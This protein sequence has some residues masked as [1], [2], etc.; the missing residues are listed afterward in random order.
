[1]S[2][3][4]QIIEIPSAIRQKIEYKVVKTPSKD[5]DG[6]NGQYP[7]LCTINKETG[8]L[9][10]VTGLEFYLHDMFSSGHR[11]ANI[12]SNVKVVSRMMNYILHEETINGIHEINPEI[13]KRIEEHFKYKQSGE[14]VSRD[15]WYK[16]LNQIY[17][18][19]E[20][21]YEKNNDKVEFQYGPE[22][23]RKTKT[24]VRAVDD[25]LVTVHAPNT[26][27]AP[28]V[29]K[30]KKC[31]YLPNPY[32]A[33]WKEEAKMHDPELYFAIEMQTDTGLREGEL[34]NV[35]RN[36][37]YVPAG[38]GDI[39]VDIK[40]RPE[41]VKKHT[42]KTP[43]GAIKRYREQKVYPE[44]NHEFKKA[45]KEHLLREEMKFKRLGKVIDPNGPLFTNKY[46]EPLT[47]HAYNERCKKL[48]FE[49]FVPDLEA[50]CIATGQYDANK[51]LIDAYK[52][53]FIGC[54]AHRHWFTMHLKVTEK[55]DDVQVANWRGDKNMTSYF[56]YMHTNHEILENFEKVSFRFQT[57]VLLAI[58]EGRGRRYLEGGSIQ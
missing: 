56:T 3:N 42:G 36:K 2:K 45:Y 49:H 32:L 27:T 18:F 20:S 43:I 35:A 8:R 21:Y 33:L 1:M 37:I 26:H 34:M 53:E 15:T 41:F 47:V 39:I 57:E 14:Q 13:L 16:Y 7:A 51:A 54:H 24:F 28:P 4:D 58:K 29:Q 19:L 38:P 12:E 23:F 6:G 5:V 48:F 31:R 50:Y 40:E 52:K 9:N 30:Q 10:S 11:L 55:L 25:K 17:R 46:G 44:F 22:D